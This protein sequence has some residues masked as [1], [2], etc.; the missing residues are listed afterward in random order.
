MLK[1]YINTHI[2]IQE[3]T[4]K[5]LETELHEIEKS[6]AEQLIK[7]Q[8]QGETSIIDLKEQHGKEIRKIK[9]E[10]ARHLEDQLDKE[11]LMFAERYDYSHFL[12]QIM[13]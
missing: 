9:D 12:S 13:M 10:A 6:H 11:R 8:Q 3:M 4:V 1:N 7:Y 2:F 5:G